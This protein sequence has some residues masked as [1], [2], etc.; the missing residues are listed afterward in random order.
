MKTINYRRWVISDLLKFTEIQYEFRNEDVKIDT[1]LIP[2]FVYSEQGQK[3]LSDQLMQDRWCVFFAIH[4]DKIIWFV[5]G[6]FQPW[7]ANIK[8]GVWWYLESV[9]VQSDYRNQSIGKQLIDLFVTWAKEK[10]CDHLRLLTHS[11]NIWARR[12]YEKM[13]MITTSVYYE[14]EI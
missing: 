10:G 4:E 3:E 6:Y 13:G 7:L 11:T 2:D 9:Y 8:H 5:C 12:L 1:S 14:K